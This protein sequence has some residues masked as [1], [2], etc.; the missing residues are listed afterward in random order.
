Q[1]LPLR[2]LSQHVPAG[3]GAR[4]PHGGLRRHRLAARP[5]TRL[6]LRAGH[7]RGG[8]GARPF[9]PRRRTIARGGGAGDGAIPRH[10]FDPRRPR[11]RRERARADRRR[12]ARVN[13]NTASLARR[14]LSLGTANAIDYALQFLLPIVLTRTLD[15]HSFGQYRL[16]WLAVSTL[17]L[18]APMCMAP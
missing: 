7:L 1:H 5:R 15:P 16:L 17:M 18:I 6:R 2:G 13:A 8:V 11:P 12:P 14:A 3:V 9:D 4:H 10:A